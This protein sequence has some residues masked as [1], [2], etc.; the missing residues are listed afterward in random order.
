M[1]EKL[2][3]KNKEGRCKYC[4]CTD[5][6]ACFGGCYWIKPNVCSNCVLKVSGLKNAAAC[7]LD[8]HDVKEARIT[9]ISKNGEIREFEILR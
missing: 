2:S 6:N 1:K 3:Q 7:Y 4:G 9:F 5:D 8:D